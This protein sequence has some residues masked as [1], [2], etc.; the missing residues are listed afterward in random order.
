MAYHR[1]IFVHLKL[2]VCARR[3]MKG[4][5]N[6]IVDVRWIRGKRYFIIS[7]DFFVCLLM[8]I[9]RRDYFLYNY[10]WPKELYLFQSL[11]IPWSTDFICVY[12]WRGDKSCGQK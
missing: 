1:H 9:F 4:S 5:V 6:S 8:V 10:F 2:R 3:R 12:S 7:L 11:L